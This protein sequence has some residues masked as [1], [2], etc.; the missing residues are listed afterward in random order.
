MNESDRGLLDVVFA[1]GRPLLQ[2]TALS[3][4]FSGCFAVFLAIRVSFF[5]TTLPS[6]R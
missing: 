5:P 6:Y 2:L 4:L 3:L 1:D